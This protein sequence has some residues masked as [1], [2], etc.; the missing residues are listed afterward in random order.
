MT[1]V[2]CTACGYV[3]NPA[4]VTKGSFGIELIL[5]LCF[6]I[7]GL[8]YSIWRLSSRHEACPSCNNSSLIPAA[9]PMAKK[10]LRENL[11][12]QVALSEDPTRPPSK[13]GIA[14]GRALGHFVGRAFKK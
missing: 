3:G 9:S 11:P 8:I 5:W 12:D 7:P 2:V 6:L 1:K 13:A 4:K 14:A 10:F